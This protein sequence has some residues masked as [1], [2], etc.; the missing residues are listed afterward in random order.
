M[1]SILASDQLAQQTL[2]WES[3]TAHVASE[4]EAALASESDASHGP[5]EAP[6]P[7]EP[8]VAMERY[9]G[10]RGIT[11]MHDGQIFRRAPAQSRDTLEKLRQLHRA[12]PAA[13][14][15]KRAKTAHCVDG[16][17]GL[18]SYKHTGR[19]LGM[20]SKRAGHAECYACFLGGTGGSG[21]CTHMNVRARCKECKDASIGGSSFCDHGKRRAQCKECNDAGTGGS[22]ICDHG[23]QRAQCK[24]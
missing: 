11:L 20:D 18:C 23:K 6:P 7:P 1:S 9:E 15:G 14:A 22:G 3:D 12:A 8:S 24:E 21:I 17:A 2:P 5:S 13:A 4:P 10:S 19:C 16:H